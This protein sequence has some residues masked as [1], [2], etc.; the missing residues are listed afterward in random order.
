MM[1]LSGVSTI[2]FAGSYAV[3]LLLELSR[4]VSR[5]AARRV[6]TIGFAGAGLLAHSAF[7]YY[8][9]ASRPGS[10]LSSPREWYLL[11][12]WLLVV[13]YLYLAIYHPRQAFGL[14]LLPL[15]L[16]LVGVATFLA[17]V[18]PFPRES[19]SRVWGAV[20]GA[21]I[22]L[23]TVVVLFGLA[24]GL[25][26]LEQARRLKRKRPPLPGLQLPSL[27]W[28]D[29]ANSRA[30]VVSVVL[31]GMAVISGLVLTSLSHGGQLHWTDP[32]VLGTLIMFAWLAAAA[33]VSLFYKPARAGRKVAYLT[34]VSFVFLVMALGVGLVLDTGHGGRR[35]TDVN[36]PRVEESL[37]ETASGRL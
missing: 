1:S 24:T 27:E 15:V 30:V 16:G 31:V 18:E 35:Q 26:Y 23:A 28:L 4:L 7:L 12:A 9:A 32:V 22:L 36:E 17:P 14:F 19:A 25:M 29:R 2:C 11:A 13:V 6:A 34:L 21:S 20:H 5:S 37:D 8:R 33:V 3:A 10:P